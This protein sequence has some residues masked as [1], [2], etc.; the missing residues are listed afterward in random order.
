MRPERMKA[1]Q[2]KLKKTAADRSGSESI[3]FLGTLVPLLLIVLSLICIF[4]YIYRVSTLNYICRRAVRSIEI[5]GTYNPTETQ[6]LVDRLKAKNAAPVEVKVTD[7]SGTSLNGANCKIQLRNTFT[8]TLVSSY[9]PLFFGPGGTS[10]YSSW[11]NGTIPITTSVS[12]MSEVFFKD[13]VPS[14]EGG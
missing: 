3:E 14:G 12:G 7:A 11:N 1:I 13:L 6:T 8:V 2:K 9:T 5:T 10:K 4:A